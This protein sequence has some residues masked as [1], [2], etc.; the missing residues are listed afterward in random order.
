MELLVQGRNKSLDCG[1]SFRMQDSKS[2]Q[3]IEMIRLIWWLPR[4]GPGTDSLE[5]LS[6]LF[7]I[8][9]S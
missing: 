9:W 3:R 7:I 2:I 5:L 4:L 8:R 6:C 1:Q